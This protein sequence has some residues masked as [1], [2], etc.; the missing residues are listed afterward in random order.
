MERGTHR[1]RKRWTA[2]EMLSQKGVDGD[3]DRPRALE[4]PRQ[5]TKRDSEETIRE[6][7]SD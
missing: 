5:V 2:G 4:R 6:V 3:T 1:E 7:Q